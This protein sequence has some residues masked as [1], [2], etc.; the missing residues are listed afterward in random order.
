MARG[1]SGGEKQ[2]IDGNG[3]R[4]E[5]PGTGIVEVLR[6]GTT[7]FP[8]PDLEVD[9]DHGAQA[10]ARSPGDQGFVPRSE[11]QELAADDG[12]PIEEITEDGP[13]ESVQTINRA[14][15]AEILRDSNQPPTDIDAPAEGH[16]ELF[17]PENRT[18]LLDDLGI[19]ETERALEIPQSGRAVSYLILNREIVQAQQSN[20]KFKAAIARLVK[21]R[22]YHVTKDE[23]GNL[24]FITLSER[25]GIK[26]LIEK[27]EF[28]QK[29]SNGSSMVMTHGWIT[30]TEGGNFTLSNYPNTSPAAT[31]RKKISKQL[32]LFVPKQFAQQIKNPNNRLGSNLEIGFEE[33]G[34]PYYVKLKGYKE[35]VLWERGG[36]RIMVGYKTQSDQFTDFLE[37][38]TESGIL[39]LE[40]QAGRGKSRFLR[41]HLEYNPDC[42]LTSMDADDKSV[43]GSGLATLARQLGEI[44]EKN[45]IPTNS[46]SIRPPDT[47]TEAEDE[48][49]L[50]LHEDPLDLDAMNIGK[51]CLLDNL[52]QLRYAAKHPDVL[53]RLSLTALRSLKHKK[54]NNIIF[55]LED[56]H[57][58]DIISEPYLRNLAQEF[59]DE[60][61]GKAII[62][63]R[64]G[65]NLS[66]KIPGSLHLSLEDGLDFESDQSKLAYEFA[67]NS[68]PAQVMEGKELGTWPIKLAKLAK[69]SPWRMKTFMDR[70][71]T[72][73]NK[74]RRNKNTGNIEI[75]ARYKYLEDRDGVIDVDSTLMEQLDGMDHDENENDITNFFQESIANL[76]EKPRKVLQAIALLNGKITIKQFKAIKEALTGETT[77][78]ESKTAPE[79]EPENLLLRSGYLVKNEKDQCYEIPHEETIRVI[80]EYFT[81]DSRRIALA[82]KLYALLEE[83]ETDDDFTDD[84]A[85]AKIGPQAKQALLDLIAAEDKPDLTNEPFWQA[86]LANSK[87]CLAYDAQHNDRQHTYEVA[88][89]ILRSAPVQEAIAELRKGEAEKVSQPLKALA[90]SGLFAKAESARFITK[91][92]QA[93]TAVADLKAIHAHHKAPVAQTDH[94]PLIA[95]SV[96]IV[97]ASSILFEVAYMDSQAQQMRAIYDKELKSGAIV[98]PAVKIM[99]EIKLANKELRFDNAKALLV[100]NHETLKA[101]S[102]AYQAAFGCDSPEYIDCWRIAAGRCPY[103]KTRMEIRDFHGPDS[104][105]ADV[106]M[107]PRYTKKVH[108]SALAEHVKHLATVQKAHSRNPRILNPYSHL[109]MLDQAACMQAFLGRFDDAYKT[110]GQLVESG[111][112][113]DVKLPALRGYKLWGDVKIVDAM[114][115]PQ[116]DTE[117]LA[118]AIAIYDNGVKLSKTTESTYNNLVRVQRLRSLSILAESYAENKN[119]KPDL[120]LNATEVEQLKTQIAKAFEDFA[121]LSQNKP[122]LNDVEDP[123]HASAVYDIMTS[124]GHVIKAAK[125]FNLKTPEL[126]HPVFNFHSLALGMGLSFTKTDLEFGEVARKRRGLELLMDHLFAIKTPEH[127]K[128]MREI[129][130]ERLARKIEATAIVRD[131]SAESTTIFEPAARAPSEAP[132]EAG[133][134]LQIEGKIKTAANTAKVLSSMHKDGETIDTALLHDFETRKFPAALAAFK[135]LNTQWPKIAEQ[136]PSAIYQLMGLMGVVFQAATDLKI[137]ISSD[138]LEDL[139]K[140][141]LSAIAAAIDFSYETHSGEVDDIKLKRHGLDLFLQAIMTQGKKSSAAK[142]RAYRAEYE[143]ELAAT[144]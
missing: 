131:A 104:A 30:P 128:Q 24:V 78:A 67:Y 86:Y 98:S 79:E 126:D 22:Y 29:V 15:I 59:K 58:A 124:L 37:P 17:K 141:N 34:H 20:V 71:L 62:S 40:A 28:F 99:M 9:T 139:R 121:Y 106:S 46:F 142:D 82:K 13:G 36:P 53:K 51:F 56:L 48:D 43:Y 44:L 122:S 2:D 66:T 110:F 93:Q 19:T 42:V 123:E 89:A 136:D 47:Q 39:I 113:I 16:K 143:A 116:L 85:S 133:F 1:T 144:A 90:I 61:L 23:E 72:L 54:Q 118:E 21:T 76:D 102:I 33:I 132:S 80:K 87:A 4:E 96:D 140:I 14:A 130:E 97:R 81:K 8:A 52:Q 38:K 10:N 117:K 75:V 27:A 125:S 31:F 55:V 41:E 115:Q 5:D 57:H 92:E 138:I 84:K 64:P 108:R 25:G 134:L 105:D 60:K 12:S 101:H 112:Q 6:R 100:R 77:V 3:T 88:E 127:E 7:V 91:F 95:D 68:I 107:M 129:T 111:L 65:T 73:E 94:Y 69:K 32:D 103:E 50:D 109:Q 49:G 11:A 18:L 45:G 70:I 26:P 120:P 63:S 74:P 83:S 135:R 114:S 119:A 35:K 137:A